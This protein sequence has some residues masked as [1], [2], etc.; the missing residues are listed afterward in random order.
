MIQL[1]SYQEAFMQVCAVKEKSP[2]NY[3]IL[4]I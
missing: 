4:Y 1:A 2:G 3:T